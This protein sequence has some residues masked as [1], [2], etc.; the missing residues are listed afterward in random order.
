MK[1]KL[2]YREI[3][4]NGGAG[5]QLCFKVENESLSYEPLLGKI[6]VLFSEWL[7]TAPKSCDEADVSDDQDGVW[8]KE[9]HVHTYE[10]GSN[11]AVVRPVADVLRRLQTRI[12]TKNETSGVLF[13]EAF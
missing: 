7:T 4:K 10:S 6:G 8:V 5:A 9:D 2:F 11:L 3:T 1:L 12:E 13:E